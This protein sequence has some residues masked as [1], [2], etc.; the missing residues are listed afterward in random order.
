M[1]TP[2]DRQRQAEEMA[3]KFADDEF[4]RFCGTRP[5]R[6]WLERRAAYLQGWTDADSTPPPQEGDEEKVAANRHADTKIFKGKKPTKY[7]EFE[8]R[9]FCI[10]D[11][12]AGCAHARRAHNAE[13]E[14][15]KEKVEQL[16]FNNERF[17]QSNQR[18]GL[19]VNELLS[20]LERAM[21]YIKEGKQKFA[22]NTTNS[23]V[24]ELIQDY[25]RMKGKQ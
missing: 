25:E 6:A 11:F 17:M 22:P 14:R 9:I 12:L 20:F 16:K 15:L 10:D 23:L 18:L 24:D 3:N 2:N 21:R 4:E 13:V 5:N 1:T 7:D 19:E 8:M